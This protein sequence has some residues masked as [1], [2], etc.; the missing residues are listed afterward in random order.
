MS[1]KFEY[2]EV[3][4]EGLEILDV[5][6]QAGKF[7]HWMYSTIR[8]YCSG[9]ILEVGSGVGNI[10]QF[11]VSEKADIVVSDIRENY[12]EIL[13]NKFKLP[14]SNVINIDI[15]HTA[16]EKEYAHLIGTFDSVF[17][18]NVV[19]HIED[20]NLAIS[21]MMK[22]LKKGGKLLVLVPAYQA[23]YN[24]FDVTLEHYRRYNETN[25]TALMHKHGKPITSF[26]FNAIG[27]AG[28][29]VS[30]SVMKNKSI[31]EGEMKLY[32]TLVPIFKIVDRVLF[33]K[34]GLSVICVIEKN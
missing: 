10:S 23:L 29:W 13:K 28:W 9:R 3:D 8:P 27:I 19:E 18:L 6:S 2:K 4:S 32:N 1:S 33:N 11:F 15:A 12:R 31:P 7:N 24:G 34:I 14:D 30:G 17:A 16:F 21:N 25:L 22:L 5:I 26:Y 20:D